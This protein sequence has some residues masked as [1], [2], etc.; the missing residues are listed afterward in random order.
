MSLLYNCKSAKAF[1]DGKEVDVHFGVQ[2]DG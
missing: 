2:E 1:V